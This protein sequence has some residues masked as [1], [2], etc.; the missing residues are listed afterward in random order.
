MSVEYF[1]ASSPDA[2]KTALGLDAP[3]DSLSIYAASMT[4]SWLAAMRTVFESAARLRVRV[5]LDLLPQASALLC[6]RE[7]SKNDGRDV[8]ALRHSIPAIFHPKIYVA[9]RGDAVRAVIGSS[10]ASSAAF[11]RNVEANLLLRGPKEGPEATAIDATIAKVDDSIAARIAAGELVGFQLPQDPIPVIPPDPVILGL[12]DPDVLEVINTDGWATDARYEDSEL[13][14]SFTS[15]MSGMVDTVLRSSGVPN[16]GGQGGFDIPKSELA[17]VEGV[18][19]EYGQN[20]ELA[21]RFVTQAGATVFAV[22][23]PPRSHGVRLSGVTGHHAV[24]TATL[25]LVARPAYRALL[26]IGATLGKADVT[27]RL[28]LPSEPGKPARLWMIHVV[29][30][31]AGAFGNSDGSL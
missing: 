22:N 12:F 1:E 27:Y 3:V 20:L 26:A 21:W 8:L 31:N 6:L 15:P 14:T 28:E 7:I 4:Y 5:G 9:V 24:I 16:K 13:V 29:P 30:D 18:L 23:E 2:L 19:K 11:G 10:N 25:G 17:A